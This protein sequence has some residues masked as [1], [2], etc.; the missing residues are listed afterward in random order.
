MTGKTFE[1]TQYG[2]VT[3][4]SPMAMSV[5]RALEDAHRSLEG[6]AISIALPTAIIAPGKTY[7]IA[8][9]F[10]TFD[11]YN[12]AGFGAAL[13]LTDNV[14]LNAAVGVGFS[15]HTS[16]ARVGANFSW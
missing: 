1:N 7:A 13:K 9:D 2:P 3:G 5:D 12:A 11:A 16:A 10:G 4:E 15:G 8:A 14:Q 6:V